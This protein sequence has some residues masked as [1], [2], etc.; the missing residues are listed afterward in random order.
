MTDAVFAIDC[1]DGR[2][3]VELGEYLDAAAA[4]R[5]TVDAIAW[6]KSLRDAR[7]DG[8]RLRQRFTLRGDS[9]WWFAELYLHKQQVILNVFRALHALEALVERERPRGASFHPGR[10]NRAGPGT[11]GR[12]CEARRLS[13]SA[14]IWTVFSPAARS[15]ESESRKPQRRGARITAPRRFGSVRSA[16]PNGRG[17]RSPRVLAGGCRRRQRRGVHRPRADGARAETR[18]RVTRRT[19]AS[20]R[21]S[22]FERG[23][24]GILCARANQPRRCARSR[25][26]RHSP[27]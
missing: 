16:E 4:E 11:T 12:R 19:S 2:R 20:A 14:G 8:Q 27:P 3:E 22:T 10:G 5:A 9:L 24:G 7:V 23:A 21:R 26:L 13:R 6:I 15:D 25:P 17:L 1:T 18:C